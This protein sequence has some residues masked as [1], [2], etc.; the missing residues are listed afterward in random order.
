M[1]Q[2]VVGLQSIT[3]ADSKGEKPLMSEGI[4]ALVDSTVPYLWLPRSACQVFETVFGISMDPIHNLYLVNEST[5]DTLMK[6][7]PSV[8]FSLANAVTGGPSVNITLPYASFDLNASHPLVKSPSRYF[9]LQIAADDT[10]YT[11]GRTFLQEAYMIVDYENSTFSLSQSVHDAANPSHIVPIAANNTGTSPASP[12][13]TGLV[14][15]TDNSSHGIGTGAIAGLA[16]AIAV[17]GILVAI[18][19]FICMRRRRR[20]R[21]LS[22]AEAYAMSHGDASKVHDTQGRDSAD[23]P[24][25]KKPTMDVTVAEGPMT[26]LSEIDGNEYLS[27]RTQRTPFELPGALVPR[28]ELS[29]PN[30]MFPPELPSPDPQAIRS[31][32]STPEPLWPNSELPTPDPSKELGSQE[33]K[34]ELPSPSLSAADPHP[35]P[36]LGGDR[37]AL[38]SPIPRLPQQ[39]PTSVRMD[40]SESESGFTYDG[41]PI[42]RHH[43]L[44]S[45]ESNLSI[46]ARRPVP[47]RMDSDLSA[48]SPILG[49][50]DF[51]SSSSKMESP[52]VA[53]RPA[54]RH[55]LPKS[56]RP[57]HSRLNSADSE[58]WETRLQMSSSDESAPPSRF[59]TIVVKHTRDA[60]DGAVET[61]P[62]LPRSADGG[63]EAKD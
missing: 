34:H 30:P 8:I 19:A 22:E 31:E 16:I 32:L 11:L 14:K 49:H 24:E 21:K 2:L 53:E 1:R 15:T 25:P 50:K 17:V 59:G 57:G 46:S 55:S 26:P 39:R 10:A 28:S 5:H 35:S 33:S 54:M 61:N 52:T 58:T 6:T 12:T 62:M 48:E 13:A 37:S 63:S 27:S 20:A 42:F 36:A 60:S 18:T 23:S 4:L 45:D 9:P 40:S 43:R 51:F 38:N 56:S 44:H 47:R 29:T 7:N 41:M 3:Y